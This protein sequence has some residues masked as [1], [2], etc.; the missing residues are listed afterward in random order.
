VS[1]PTLGSR[2]RGMMLGL[3]VGDALGHPTEFISSLAQIKARYGDVSRFHP[4]GSHPAGTFTDDTQMSIAV[5]RALIRQGRACDLDLLMTTMAG[6]FVAW[7]GH[8]TNNRAPGGTCLAG[9]RHLKEGRP[10]RE[11]GVKN[12]KG[13]GAAMRAAPVG[14]FYFD[15]DDLLLEVAAAQ[16][17]LT[18][19]HPTAI[20]S[21]VA[22]AAATAYL[23][24]GGALHGLLGHVQTQVLRLTDDRLLSLGADPALIKSVGVREQTRLF[25]KTADLLQAGRDHADVCALLGGAWVGEEAAAGALWCF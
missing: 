11:A 17:V 4:A 3:A 7:A 23:A 2:A 25:E 9:C 19:S 15:D 20:A 14:L 10:W 8:P 18:H 24:R 16:S 5:A 12:S 1:P 13:C 21:S 6:E 22:V